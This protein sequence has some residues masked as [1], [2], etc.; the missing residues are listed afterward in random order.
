MFPILLIAIGVAVLVLGKRLALFPGSS[1]PW[2]TF[3]VPIGLALV[4]FFAAAFA[5]GLI[6]IVILALGAV[7]GAAIVLAFLDLFGIDAGWLR[8]LLAAGGGVAGFILIRRFRKGPRDWGMLILAGLVGALLVTRGL[9]QL[10]PSLQDSISTLIVIVLAGGSIA[11]QGGFLGRG[12]AAEAA[13]ASTQEGA[14]TA[15]EDQSAPTSSEG[16]SSK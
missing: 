15:A 5:K 14:P 3:G 8:W 16:T 11:Y 6:N 9:T 7:A 12:E 1:G 4:G 13:P 10:L 2:I